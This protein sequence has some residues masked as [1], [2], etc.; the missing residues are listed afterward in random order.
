VLR[1]GQAAL[2][3]SKGAGF[4]AGHPAERLVRESMFFLVWSCPQSCRG[5]ACYSEALKWPPT[6]ASLLP[7]ADCAPAAELSLR[8][9]SATGVWRGRRGLSHRLRLCGTRPCVVCS[10]LIE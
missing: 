7:Q 4:V 5:R 8:L 10:L 9:R 1:A 2:T 6:P 3:A